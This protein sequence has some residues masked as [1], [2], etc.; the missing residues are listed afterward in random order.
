[1][2]KRKGTESSWNLKKVLVHSTNQDLNRNKIWSKTKISRIKVTFWTTFE[3]EMIVQVSFKKIWWLKKDWRKFQ[4]LE[5]TWQKWMTI[6]KA[7]K[8]CFKRTQSL[9]KPPEQSLHVHSMILS[10]TSKIKITKKLLPQ[11]R[12]SSG[13]MRSSTINLAP[14][15]KTTKIKITWLT[16]TPRRTDQ[17]ISHKRSQLLK[18]R[19]RLNPATKTGS[20]I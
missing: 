6:R 19:Q 1:M 15:K 20:K 2:L 4:L 13:K 14:Q 5:K 12:N 10:L 3:E 11:S 8:T 16:F 17:V 18:R 9:E 7:I